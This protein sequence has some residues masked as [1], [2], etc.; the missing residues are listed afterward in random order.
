L[1][2][3]LSAVAVP[4]FHSW[5][6]MWISPE[7]EYYS[8]KLDTRPADFDTRRMNFL[9]LQRYLADL[10]APG[11][12]IHRICDDSLQAN[13]DNLHVCPSLVALERLGTV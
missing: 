4:P 6:A 5:L 10:A 12:L 7:L 8:D 11:A 13:S 1:R 3:K 9:R 2:P